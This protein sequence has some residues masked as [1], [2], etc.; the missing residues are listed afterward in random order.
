MHIEM[1]IALLSF[2]TL[3]YL[4]IVLPDKA[5]EWEPQPID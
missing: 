5:N 1:L 2:I 3:A 4:W